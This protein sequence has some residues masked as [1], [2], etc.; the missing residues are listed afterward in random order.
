[1]TA[2]LLPPDDK[3]R[4]SWAGADPLYRRYHDLEWGRPV[5]SD[6]RLFEKLCLEGFQSGLSWITILRKRERFREVFHGFDIAKV[7]AMDEADIERL[8]Q[9]AG[10]IRHRGKIAATINN[11][12][13]SLEMQQEFGSLAAYFWRFETM[14]EHRPDDLSWE[15]LRRLCNYFRLHKAKPFLIWRVRRLHFAIASFTV[16]RTAIQSTFTEQSWA[17]V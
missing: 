1:M 2:E 8:L 12:K 11:A 15:S 6:T 14:P 5:V 7:A 3:P 16:L 17:V 9:D 4:C 13:R 10:I